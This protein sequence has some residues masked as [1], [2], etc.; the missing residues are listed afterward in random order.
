M[1]H[2]LYRLRLVD[3]PLWCF[4]FLRRNTPGAWSSATTNPPHTSAPVRAKPSKKVLTH[5]GFYRITVVQS[6]HTKSGLA[7]SGCSLCDVCFPCRSGRDEDQ[8]SAGAA[9]P[10][11]HGWEAV[12]SEP[13]ALRPG[14][15]WGE[16]GV[17]RLLSCESVGRMGFVWRVETDRIKMM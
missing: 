10:A 4:Y 8:P 1:I 14:I 3:V 5:F 9:V 6:S 16:L 12:G 17:M 13:P 7:W 2:W 11:G 15:Q